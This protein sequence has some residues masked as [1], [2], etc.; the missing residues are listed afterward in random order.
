MGGDRFPAYYHDYGHEAKFLRGAIKSVETKPWVDTDWG[1]SYWRMDENLNF[2]SHDTLREAFRSNKKLDG[3]ISTEWITLD[4]VRPLL[5]VKK[6]SELT[7]IKDWQITFKLKN[8]NGKE[9]VILSSR[10]FGLDRS[11]KFEDEGFEETV[12]ISDSTNLQE[13]A[14]CLCH[15]ILTLFQWKNPPELTI[16]NDIEALLKGEM[17]NY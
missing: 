6:L 9:L 12:N 8:I 13:L 11:Y 3:K 17:P 14:F 15:E 16:K 10:R 5:F 2:I 4:I 1:I 7:D